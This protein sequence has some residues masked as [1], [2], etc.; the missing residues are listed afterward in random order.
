MVWICIKIFF[1]RILDVSIATIRQNVM[2]KGH[3][4]KSTILAF[5]EIFI[6]FLVAREALTVGISSLWIPI[7]Y[8][9]GYATGT[10]LGSLLSKKLLKEK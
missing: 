1:A 7:S 10:L 4:F 9:L 5:M 2:L 3:Y 6:W 8:S